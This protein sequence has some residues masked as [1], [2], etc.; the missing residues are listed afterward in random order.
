MANHILAIGL[1]YSGSQ[2]A[3]RG[4]VNDARDWLAH[5]GPICAS[6]TPLIEQEATKVNILAE[7]AKILGKLAANDTAIITYSGHGT[8]IPDQSGDET[9]RRDEA[10]CPWDMQRNLLLDD[11]LRDALSKRA[12]GSRVL[13]VTDCCHSGTMTRDLAEMHFGEF[14]FPR[15]VDFYTL[16]TQMCLTAL[17]RI[18]AQA[19]AARS[20]RDVIDQGGLTHWAGCKDNE[21]SY[22]AT[23]G[24]KPCGAFTDSALRILAKAKGSTG[25]NSAAVQ[26]S[27]EKFLPSQ[28][29]PQTPQFSGDLL[30]VIPGFEV[31]AVVVP[32]S[33]ETC[34][35]I[36]SKGRKFKVIIE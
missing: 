16:S 22:D 20:A 2:N 11:E 3:L 34:E 6:A 19:R 14:Q 4:C 9:D 28:R 23:I 35:G 15:F 32:T 36:S 26:A 1:N 12:Q 10:L 24:G 13:L 31:G 25:L 18:H 30:A 33:I 5:F 17:D 27:M 21:V 7:I 8:Y 29:Y